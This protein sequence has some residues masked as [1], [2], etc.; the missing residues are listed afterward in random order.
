MRSHRVRQKLAEGGLA[1]GTMVFEFAT[2]GIARIAAAAGADFVLF[3]MEHTGW[4]VESLRMLLATTPPAVAPMVRVPA[5]EYHFIAR[6]L[7]VGATGIMVPMVESAEQAQR[8]VQA[9]KYPPQGRRGTAFGVAHDDYTM[10]DILE[11]MR[12][13]NREGLLIA[14]IETARGLENVDRIAAVEGIDVLWIGQFDLSTS[15]GI[16]GQF[17]HADFQRAMDRVLAAARQHNK[18]AG[19]MLIAPEHAA[20]LC[21]RGFRIL[22]YSGDIWIYQ[23]ALRDGIAA[24]RCSA[25]C[26]IRRAE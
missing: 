17:E 10:G 3:D 5:T 9:A 1:V 21:Q 6:V 12:S 11:T 8:I 20:P 19:Y 2:T 14:Q 16:P 24:I 22:A 7:D 13:A 23:N 15:L 26:G 25:E 4:S 18:W